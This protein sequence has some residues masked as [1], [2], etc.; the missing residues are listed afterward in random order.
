MIW[1]ETWSVKGVGLSARD[2][3]GAPSWRPQ[4]ASGVR[5]WAQESG[6]HRLFRHTLVLKNCCFQQSGPTAQHEGMWGSVELHPVTREPSSPSAGVSSGKKSCIALDSGHS[7][8]YPRPSLC[9]DLVPGG[10][11]TPLGLG[12]RGIT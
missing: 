3:A 2:V 8:S 11:G 9:V 4:W 10:T 5:G 1:G 12:A 7:P 6:M